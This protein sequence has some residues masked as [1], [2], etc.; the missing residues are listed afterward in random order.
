MSGLL[1]L[2]ADLL[3]AR[4]LLRAVP[5]EVPILAAVVAFAAIHALAWNDCQKISPE[6]ALLQMST[7]ET[8]VRNRRRSSRSCPG[9]HRNRRHHSH[10]R[11]SFHHTH[12]GSYERC[13]RPY[14]TDKL[15]YL[16]S[17]RIE[18]LKLPYSTLE[19]RPGRHHRWDRCH[20]SEGSHG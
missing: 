13:D 1:A 5:R 8:C 10:R 16:C 12:Q 7:Y 6:D 19:I 2:V 17:V 20:H 18:H 15:C 9:R 11:R 4:G 14:R 3:T